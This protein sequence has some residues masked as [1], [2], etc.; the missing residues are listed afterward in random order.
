MSVSAG[1]M[2]LLVG[3]LVTMG[4]SQAVAQPFTD[5]N[6]GL[7]GVAYSAAAWG[8]YDADGDLDVA[9]SG[10]MSGL[11][12][13]RIYRNDA[14]GGFTHVA[15]CAVV[16]GDDHP[17]RPKDYVPLDAFWARRGYTKADGL[18]CRL[19]W[20]DIDQPVQT[21]KPMQFWMRAL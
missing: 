6:A 21:E 8:D 1:K 18:V 12:T 16:R 4:R 15:F 10:Q 14:A 19:A 13:T 9:L 7:A 5:I 2:R 11:E 3:I 20:K 17:L